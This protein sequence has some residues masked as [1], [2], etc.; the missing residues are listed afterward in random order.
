MSRPVNKEDTARVVAAHQ[1]KVLLLRC[2]RL[3]SVNLKIGKKIT[4]LE[5]MTLN[6]EKI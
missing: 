5:I 1:N 2:G 3:I 6:C 4:G